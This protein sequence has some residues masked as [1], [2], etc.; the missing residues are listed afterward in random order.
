M[1]R[2]MTPIGV[3]ISSRAIAPRSPTTTTG[4]GVQ[5]RSGL[6]VPAPAAITLQGVSKTFHLPHQKRTRLKERAAQRFGSRPTDVLHALDDVGFEVGRRRVLRDRRAQRQRQE[7]AAA[8][9][10]RHLRH[11]LPARSRSTAGCRPSSSWGSASTR[12]DQ[13][14]ERAAER[15]DARPGPPRRRARGSTTM[16]AFA[17]LEQFAELKLKNYSSGM[18]VRLAFSVARPGG[19]RDPAVRRGPRGG[20]RRVSGQMLRGVR[21]DAGAR[22]ARSCFVTHDMDAIER[23]CDRAM[24][25]ERGEVV[26]VGEPDS[27]ARQYVAANREPGPRT[28]ASTRR[29]QAAAHRR[30]AIAAPGAALA[31]RRRHSATIRAASPT[32]TAAL[33]AMDFKRALPGLGARLPVARCCA[34]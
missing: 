25:L 21:A 10:R 11:R 34:R 13:P 2:W 27:I 19:R 8:L 1:K 29:A 17:E 18:R 12:A 3:T 24:L 4:P 31:T 20:R 33:A 6:L 30:L 26:D 5:E 16:L 28:R 9:H 23:F 15:G 7:H 32:L 22:A 14:R